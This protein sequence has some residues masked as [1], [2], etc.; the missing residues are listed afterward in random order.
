VCRP[1]TG[2]CD[3]PE[4]CDGTNL[5]CPS[6]ELAPATT[7]CR[8][9]AGECDQAETCTGASSDCPA[10]LAAGNG[11]PC[12]DGTFCNGA[13]TCSGGSCSNH[14]GDPCPGADGDGD[15]SESC[16]E[17]SDACSAADPNG[18]ACDDGNVCTVDDQCTGG[19]CSGDVQANG[20]EIC[21]P[22]TTTTLPTCLCGDV[23]LDG[24]IKA[25]DALL[26]LNVS[27][28][29]GECLPCACDFNG[30]GTITAGDA[31]GILRTAVSLPTT[32][33]CPD[34]P[35]TELNDTTTTLPGVTSTT[36]ENPAASQP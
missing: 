35:E 34:Q 6:D 1:G 30:N 17:A 14:A 9:A 19:V 13:D 5:A 11:T 10:D 2:V 18:A 20:S 22:T 32:P 26:A 24:K 31:L 36:L 15:C 7:T 16:S 28:G 29:I 25:G 27:V 3:A 33:A 12:N 21:P 4:T 23:N 8:A